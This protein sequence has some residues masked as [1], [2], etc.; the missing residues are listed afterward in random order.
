MMMISKTNKMVKGY[1]NEDYVYSS[2]VT[3]ETSYDIDLCTSYD[4][5]RIKSDHVCRKLS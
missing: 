1:D 2:L 3:T 4:L 5:F